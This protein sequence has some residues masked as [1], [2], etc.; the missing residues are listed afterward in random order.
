MCE[1]Y[2]MFTDTTGKTENY[3]ACALQKMT[4]GLVLVGEET[5]LMQ[6]KVFGVSIIKVSQNYLPFQLFEVVIEYGCFSYTIC[7]INET[8]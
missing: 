7:F 4:F 2:S 8:P 1:T 5:S 6:E 3:C